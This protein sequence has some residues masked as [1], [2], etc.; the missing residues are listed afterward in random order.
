MEK[1][2]QNLV[3]DVTN[4]NEEIVMAIEKLNDGDVYGDKLADSLGCIAE[5]LRIL[6][7]RQEKPTKIM[8]SL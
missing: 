3:K 7:G 8:K 2:L 4:S 1:F 6:S 5:S